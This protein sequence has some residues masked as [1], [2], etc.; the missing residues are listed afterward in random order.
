[1]SCWVSSPGDSTYVSPLSKLKPS[2]S[3]LHTVRPLAEVSPW[4]RQHQVDLPAFTEVMWHIILL[5][6]I[7]TVS[8]GVKKY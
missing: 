6:L 1:L 4:C 8:G 7:N 2:S 5:N 3:V